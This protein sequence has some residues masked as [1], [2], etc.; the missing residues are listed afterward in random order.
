MLLTHAHM[1]HI[2][3]AE[4]IAKANHASV[5]ANPELSAFMS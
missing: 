3:D 2:L 1:D 5:V 4:P